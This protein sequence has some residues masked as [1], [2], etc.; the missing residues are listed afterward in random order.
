MEIT[1]VNQLFL[2]DLRDMYGAE[3]QIVTTIPTLIMRTQNEALGEALT[4]HL[5]ET[6]EHVKR[7]Q[8]IFEL[9]GEPP[10]AATCDSMQSLMEEAEELVA[11]TSGPARDLAICAS[12][13]KVEH[14][15]KAAY[16]TL[17]GLADHMN[18]TEEANL[19]HET[20]EEER[21]ASKKL[22]TLNKVLL[23]ETP[24]GIK[25]E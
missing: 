6:N 11:Q 12:I 13:Q 14:Y 5:K 4:R 9:L 10:A 16:K 19:L 25:D 1:T 22:L 15:E 7:L 17:Y 21:E 18:H 3:Q 24:T 23:Q 2:H 20:L 8:E